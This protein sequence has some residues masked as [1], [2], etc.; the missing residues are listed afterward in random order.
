MS[1]TLENNNPI[2]E[3]NK[4]KEKDSLVVSE[5]IPQVYFFT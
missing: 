3:E 4:T 1:S 5:N 2:S